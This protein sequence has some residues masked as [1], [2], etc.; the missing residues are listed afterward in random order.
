MPAKPAV[1]SPVVV[2]GTT[3]K[4][5]RHVSVQRGERRGRLR[6][7]G[8]VRPAVDGR[9]VVIQKLRR[10]TG[11]WY[12]IGRTVTRHTGGETSRYR[13]TV[14]QRHGGRYRAVVV[15]DDKYASSASRSIKVRHVRG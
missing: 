5:T 12:T 2:V 10:S 11:V 6:F 14:R 13:K 8:R 4:V 1:F 7:R 3:V 9:E 15:M